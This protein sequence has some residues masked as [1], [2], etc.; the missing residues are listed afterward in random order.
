MGCMFA[1]HFHELTALADSIPT[2]TNLHVSALTSVNQ[3]TLLYRVEPGVCD[4]SFGIH[5]A[6]IAEFPSEVIQFAKE[7][8]SELED[9]HHTESQSHQLSGDS[10]TDMKRKREEKKNAERLIEG[11]IKRIKSSNIKNLSDS[12]IQNLIDSIKQEALST[13]NSYLKGLLTR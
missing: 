3:L 4:Q 5:V 10:G 1:T 6:E 8:A 9:F 13:N 12:E 11:Y 7:K 2:V